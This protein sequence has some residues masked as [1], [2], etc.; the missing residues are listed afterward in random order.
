MPVNLDTRTIESPSATEIYIS[1]APDQNA[2][3]DR[4]A[5]QIFSEI[6]DTL[7]SKK[8]AILQERVF[9]VK[10]VMKTISDIRLK[11]YGALDDGVAPS[12]LVCTEGR[13]GPIAGVQVHAVAADTTPYVIDFDG[14]RCGRI[15]RLPNRTYLALSNI[16]AP[17]SPQPTQQAAAMLEKG[18]AILKQSGTDMLSV[19]RT[20]MW[21]ADILSWYDDFNRVRNKFFTER[22][23]IGQ[24]TRQSMPA[25]TGIGLAPAGGAQCAMDLIA[26]LEPTDSVQY[27]PAVGKQHCALEYGSAFSRA[28]KAATPAAETVFVSGTA[29]IDAEGRTTNIDDPEGQ[30]NSTIENVRAVLKDM[31]CADSD[32]V[33]AVAYCK[34]TDVEKI[35]NVLKGTLPWPWLTAICDI[36]RPDL[37]FEIEAAATLNQ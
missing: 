26:I 4:Q 22:G 31:N 20:W 19:A 6:A 28:S 11:E 37:L 5:Q 14:I 8:A 27:L 3:P 1:A 17:Q 16:S 21:L 15:L 24:N 30:I 35:F 36:C 18:E 34:T 29:S 9:A 10:D 33:Q 7:R 12:I 32:V 23:I 2:P 13:C 25:S